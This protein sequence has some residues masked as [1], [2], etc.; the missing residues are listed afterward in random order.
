[1]ANAPAANGFAGAAAAQAAPAGVVAPAGINPDET[2]AA[3]YCT[4]TG[5]TVY[6]R[7]PEYDT[8]GSN[9]LV[10]A[11]RKPF[12]QYTRRRTARASTF[13]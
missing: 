2:A 1:M 9:P 10:L 12:C 4:K 11:G 3:N 5:G 13:C 7:I 8:N 6:M